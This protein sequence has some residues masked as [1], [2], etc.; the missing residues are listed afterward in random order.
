M[1]LGCDMGYFSQDDIQALCGDNSRLK[2]EIQAR[3][4]TIH[5]KVFEQCNT[6]HTDGGQL[7]GNIFLSDDVEEGSGTRFYRFKQTMEES[8]IANNCMYRKE[9]YGYKTPNLDIVNFTPSI[10][11]EKWESYFLAEE[12]FN[13]LNMYEG[14][15]FH[16][17]YIEPETYTT[18]LRKSL[19]FLSA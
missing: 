10:S 15:L 18:Q 4:L 14:A 8:P 6:P 2:S 5:K 1:H 19:S 11:N 13:C 16:S 7:A 12:K 3:F 17:A 9:L